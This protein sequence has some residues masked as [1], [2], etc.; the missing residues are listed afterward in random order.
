MTL[1]EV[2]FKHLLMLSYRINGTV[3]VVKKL[4]STIVAKIKKCKKSI[5]FTKIF[6]MCYI[7][8]KVIQ[9]TLLVYVFAHYFIKYSPH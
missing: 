8:L 5:L 7:Q 1:F 2:A 9:Q 3:S 4:F 6:G